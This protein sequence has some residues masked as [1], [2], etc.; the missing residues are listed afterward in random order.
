MRRGFAA[1]AGVGGV[2]LALGSAAAQELD[3]PDWVWIVCAVLAGGLA[4]VWLVLVIRVW[5]IESAAA[6]FA[7]EVSN[8]ASG[9]E[10]ARTIASKQR[11]LAALVREGRKLRGPLPAYGPELEERIA[12]I[13]EWSR[14]AGRALPDGAWPLG[15]SL[16]HGT[17]GGHRAAKQEDVDRFIRERVELLIAHWEDTS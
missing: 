11:E 16:G 15:A 17:F 12:G 5:T 10:K 6:A 7:D 2:A 13:E 3:A 1:A 4:L 14:R 8:V 9:Y